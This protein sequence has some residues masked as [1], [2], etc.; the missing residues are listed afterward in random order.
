MTHTY[1]VSGM[2]CGGCQAK[3]Q[4][5]LSKVSGVKNVSIDLSKGEAV[6]DMDKHIATEDLKAA[7]NDY[8]KYQLS[9]THP[10]IH[11]VVSAIEKEEGKSWIATY[12]PILLI[13][14]Y[15]TG[16]TFL[17]EYINGNFIWMRWMN[18]FMAGFFLVFSFF[19]LLNLKGFAESYSMYDIVAKKWNGWG[20]V[21]AFTELALGI[22]FLVGFNPIL[23]NSVTFVVMTVSIIGV[24]QSVLNKRKIKCAC[25]GDVFNL[26][27][28]TVTIIEDALMIGM[29]AIMLTTML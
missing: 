21:Y 11:T 16:V 26:P 5:L 15:I 20:Y 25:L 12:K 4:G 7:L 29:S 23:T 14:G 28:S 13:F 2:T 22:A 8:P 3:V 24:L 1:N 9:E 19:K 27:M 17:T 10:Q 18:H 6:I